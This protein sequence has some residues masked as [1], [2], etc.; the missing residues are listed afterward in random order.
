MTFQPKW[1]CFVDDP[2]ED[3]KFDFDLRQIDDLSFFNLDR[4]LA[5]EDEFF[6]GIIE[7]TEPVGQTNSTEELE[8]VDVFGNGGGV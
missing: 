7:E 1:K 6:V 8:E 2:D 5:C 3:Y 4:W